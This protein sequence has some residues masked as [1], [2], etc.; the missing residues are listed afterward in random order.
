[1]AERDDSKPGWYRQAESEFGDIFGADADEQRA[2]ND[3]AKLEPD[4][5]EFYLGKL[6]FLNLRAQYHIAR[7]NQAMLQELRAVAAEDDEPEPAPRRGARRAPPGDDDQPPPVRGGPASPVTDLGQL[8]PEV[9]AEIR[10]HARPV[11]VSDAVTPD[12]VI[13]PRGAAS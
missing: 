4:E 5:R 8:P 3:W 2:I 6:L 9:Q 10:R 7:T 11:V 13:P 12:E 1:V